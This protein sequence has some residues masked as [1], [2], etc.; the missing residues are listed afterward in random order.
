MQIG[1][2]CR[3]VNGC[4]WPQLS[5][6]VQIGPNRSAVSPSSFNLPAILPLIIPQF[7]TR[8]ARFAKPH[9]NICAAAC[10]SCV[11]PHLSPGPH[12][13]I[14]HVFRFHTPAPHRCTAIGPRICTVVTLLDAF[15]TSPVANMCSIPLRSRSQIFCH[16]PPLLRLL[17]HVMSCHVVI[18]PSPHSRESFL[19]PSSPSLLDTSTRVKLQQTT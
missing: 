8:S 19:P 15:S 16:A 3:P 1:H 17:H 14:C 2:I 7:C 4:C 5:E 6:T 13:S 10:L 18:D 11:F 9:E 12:P